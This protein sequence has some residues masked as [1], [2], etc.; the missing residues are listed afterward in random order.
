[1]GHVLLGLDHRP[2]AGIELPHPL[3]D[4]IN[5]QRNVIDPLFGLIE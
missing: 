2:L 1:V 3:G 4:D 5:E